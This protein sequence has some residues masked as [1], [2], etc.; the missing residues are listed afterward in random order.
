MNKQI[1]FI[2]AGN[3]GTAIVRG[4]LNTGVL[5]PEQITVAD[6]RRQALESLSGDFPR[7]RTTASIAE[8]ASADILILA[9][10]PQSYKSVIREIREQISENTVIVSIAAGLN[11]KKI[12]G[13]FGKT[14]KVIRV[15]PN[16]PALVSKGMSAVC[17]GD[18]LTGEEIQ[19]VTA[20]FD[21]VGDTVLLPEHL[22][23]AYTA[24]AGSSPAW[25]FMFIEALAD[26]AV[27]HGIPRDTA[28]RAAAQ[29]VSGSAELVL[30]TGQHPAVLKDQVC[31]PSGTTIEAVA[32][33]EEAG[34]RSA[35]IKAVNDC[36][37]KAK[38]IGAE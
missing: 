21:S 35:V 37:A 31:S 20:I 7:V 1:G 10:K 19:N 24:L 3:M 15:M 11:L 18:N 33:L 32:A 34:F 36:T 27:R 22:M 29:A 4:L 17:P 13:W 38:E 25:V 2:G 9:V 26:G 5:M 14:V 6:S 28:Y 8:A 16:T 23:D 12:S 30:S